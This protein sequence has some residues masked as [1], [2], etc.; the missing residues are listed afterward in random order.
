MAGEARVAG[1][2]VEAGEAG[3]RAVDHGGGDGVAERD[4]GVVGDAQ[5]HLVEGEDLRP[6]GVLDARGFVVEG[7]DG[8]LQ[9]VWADG[10]AGERGGDE[11]DAL[12]DRGPVPAG[13]ILLVERDQLAGRSGPRVAPRVGQEHEHDQPGGLA[14]GGDEAVEPAGQAQG[15][16]R[17]VGAM[18]VGARAG[19]VAFVEDQV[20]DVHDRAEARGAVV[21]GRRLEARAGVL[22]G[23][24]GPADPLGHGR[25]G[26]QERV[27]DLGGGEPADRAQGQRDRRRRRQRRVA[28]HE[29]QVE[30]VVVAGR[31]GLVGGER[32]LLVGR[33]QAD[34]ELLAV[35]ARGLGADVIGDPPRRDVDQ[36]R[37]RVVGPA[38]VR[39]LQR[40]RDQRLLDR[41]LGGGEV[42]VAAGHDAQHLGRELA[43]QVLGRRIQRRRGHQRW[44]LGGALMTSRTSIARYSGSPP[45]PG[46]SDASAAIW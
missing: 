36:P 8:R 3:G 22:E 43:Q 41:V 35:A 21:G 28:A 25:L 5:E 10:A 13:A 42:A 27:G 7:G 9:L 37:A 39:P 31:A 30:A 6:V 23:C 16:A 12:G 26:D 20:E 1:E 45:L 33:H 11:R 38:V 29:Q 19:G 24:L 34:H 15:L 2:G 40:R 44:S 4:H 14:V 46:A 32:D 18:D 17:Q